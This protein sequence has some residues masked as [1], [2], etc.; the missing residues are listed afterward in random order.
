MT[1]F[2]KLPF[3]HQAVSFHLKYFLLNDFVNDL[4]SF[5]LKGEII[6]QASGHLLLLKS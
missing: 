5:L 3:Q 2:K 6:L 4:G 1:H